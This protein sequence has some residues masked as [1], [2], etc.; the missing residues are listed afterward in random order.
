MRDSGQTPTTMQSASSLAF[1]WW[2]FAKQP[3]LFS[4]L[5][6]AFFFSVCHIK[7]FPRVVIQ[8]GKAHQGFSLMDLE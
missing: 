3:R 2:A 6:S 4:Q 8:T 5:G 7:P 1:D